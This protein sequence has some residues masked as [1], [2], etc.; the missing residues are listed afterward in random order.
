M[1]CCGRSIQA[2]QLNKTDS[3][4]VAGTAVRTGSGMAAQ[5]SLLVEYEGAGSLTAFGQITGRRYHFPGPGARVYVDGR[6]APVF[7]VMQGVRV[8]GEK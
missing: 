6:D 8:V 7:E 5:K 4:D 2:N 1:S 3:G